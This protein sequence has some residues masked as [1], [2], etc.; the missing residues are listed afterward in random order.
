M[1]KRNNQYDFQT[2][3]ATAI[4]QPRGQRCLWGTGSIKNLITNV[5]GPAIDDAPSALGANQHAISWIYIF[6]INLFSTADKGLLITAWPSPCGA[7]T[8]A[9]LF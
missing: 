3:L 7:F 6:W 5:N 8:A 2:K 9:F 4:P 1:Q